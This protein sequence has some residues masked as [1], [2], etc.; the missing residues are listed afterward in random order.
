VLITWHQHDLDLIFSYLNIC[1]N[2]TQG[3]CRNAIFGFLCHSFGFVCI[4]YFQFGCSV[5]KT[6][7]EKYIGISKISSLHKTQNHFT[8]WKWHLFDILQEH[9]TTTKHWHRMTMNT[10]SI[11]SQTD[12]TRMSLRA[13]TGPVLGRCC[14]HRTS[15]G[16]VPAHTGMFTGHRCAVVCVL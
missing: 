10:N 11:A 1:G 15:T 6:F 8:I 12:I 13:G 4:F 9:Q 16:L 14:Q 2:L 7:S 5:V 3:S